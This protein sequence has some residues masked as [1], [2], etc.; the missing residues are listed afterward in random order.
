MVVA[1]QEAFE[2]FTAK[3]TVCIVSH[4]PPSCAVTIHRS[5]SEPEQINS[6][7]GTTTVPASK[8]NGQYA[9]NTPKNLDLSQLTE[10]QCTL[11]GR[12]IAITLKLELCHGKNR[13]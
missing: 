2:E 8:I 7:T 5:I 11:L 10:N 13:F 12:S 4:R 6:G 3:F 9:G 1:V